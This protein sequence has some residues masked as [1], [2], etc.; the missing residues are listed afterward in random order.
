MTGRVTDPRSRRLIARQSDLRGDD[1]IFA[2]N[3]EA[4]RRSAAGEDVVNST[5]GALLDEELRLATLGAVTEAYRRVPVERGAGYAPI[6]GPQAF[7]EAVLADLLGSS[8]Q[9]SGNELA[10]SAVAVATPGGTGALALAV[11][12]FLEPGDSLLT[13]SYY[14]SPYGT[15]AAHAGRTLATFRMFAQSGRFDVEALGA[16]LEQSGARQGRSLLFLNTPCHNPTGYSLDDQDWSALAGVLASA[17]ARQELTVLLDLAYSRYGAGDPRDWVR[18]L[19]PLLGRATLLVA[20]SASKAFAQYG[21]RVGACVAFEADAR[22][23]ERVRAA[24]GASCRGTWSNCN[25]LGMLA[26][27]EC[28]SDPEL[29]A[30][31]ERERGELCALLAR[32]V[33]LF[34]HLARG[35]RLVHPRYAGGFF[36]TVFTPDAE[37]TAEHLRTRGV[38]VVPVAGAV[39]V[40]ICSTPLGAIPR[41]VEA[42]AAGVRAAGG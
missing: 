4:A 22:E 33:E 11:S 36:V 39:R 29:S 21:A 10:R 9:G 13:S 37:R 38:F 18:H 5:L 24:L 2:L 28:L 25:H 1:P 16:A 12:N 27:T 15:I 26:I 30:R 17:A 41:L 3:A 19:A 8:S 34:T 14:W 7:L 35:A 32:R 6:G 40:A 23:R 20:W 31:A 42:L